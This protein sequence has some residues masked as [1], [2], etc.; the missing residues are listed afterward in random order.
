MKESEIEFK[1]RPESQRQLLQKK[2][3]ELNTLSFLVFPLSCHGSLEVLLKHR[4]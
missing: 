4:S 3:F 1:F 2:K